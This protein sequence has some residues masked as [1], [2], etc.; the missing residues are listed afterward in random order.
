MGVGLW[1]FWAI[2]QFN[3][4]RD[5]VSHFKDWHS[6]T[7]EIRE[8]RLI[9]FFELEISGP[10]LL[11][12]FRFFSK[13][14]SLD[15]IVQEIER[16]PEKKL[17]D[18]HPIFRVPLPILRETI[19]SL[20]MILKTQKEEIHLALASALKD[21]KSHAEKSIPTRDFIDEQ[22]NSQFIG[23]WYEIRSA[24]HYA[25]KGYEILA[26]RLSFKLPL[27]KQAGE[28]DLLVRNSKQD[29]V[30]VEVKKRIRSKREYEAQFDR[31]SKILEG[32]TL[33]PWSV[34]AVEIFVPEGLSEDELEFLKS[35]WPAFRTASLHQKERRPNHLD[36][37]HY[38]GKN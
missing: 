19:R 24:A 14:W 33:F 16:F 26:F 27:L 9:E 35:N 6:H 15:E 31:F 21:L 11:E 1:V 12:A 25:E 4:C 32:M 28:I 7:S 2:S 30:L 36:L 38:P 20:E 8:Q 37:P 17:I 18:A 29:V 34:Q 10:E 23:L 3:P 22:K 13:V 5:Y